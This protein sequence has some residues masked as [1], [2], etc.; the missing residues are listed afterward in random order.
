VAAC[1]KVFCTSNDVVELSRPGLHEVDGR[2][3]A[4]QMRPQWK[5]AASQG[6]RFRAW[7]R[8]KGRASVGQQAVDETPS[9][10]L[11]AP[12]HLLHRLRAVELGADD[13]ACQ[14]E[15]P[16]SQQ[17]GPAGRRGDSMDSDDE[18]FKQLV[19][20]VNYGNLEALE[21]LAQTH[22]SQCASVINRPTGEGQTLL[23]IAVVK[24]RPACVEQLLAMG[25]D[26][27]L[28]CS[29]KKKKQ[30]ALHRA[31]EEGQAEMVCSLLT[32]RPAATDSAFRCNIYREDAAGV[33]CLQ[34]S[35]D[36][37]TAKKQSEHI[38]ELLEAKNEQYELEATE[39]YN[40]CLTFDCQA[41]SNAAKRIFRLEKVINRCPQD[42]YSLLYR[43]CEHGKT[44]VVD[45]LVR[46]GAQCVAHPVTGYTPLYV[47][48]GKGNVA[49]VERL[50]Y[51]CPKAVAIATTKE[52]MLPLHAACLE[53][54]Y[55]VAN[56]LLNFNY[57]EDCLQKFYVYS[58]GGIGTYRAAFDVNAED[59]EGY[60][61]LQLA[62]LWGH[63]DVLRCLLS[64]KVSA[65]FL[66]DQLT[67]PAGD[68]DGPVIDDSQT[69]GGGCD[70]TAAA[71]VTIVDNGRSAVRRVSPLNLRS[72]GAAVL[73]LAVTK[74]QPDVVRC[75]LGH[76]A[77]EVNADVEFDGKQ[78]YPLRVAVESGS[79][80]LADLLM[81]HG[82]VDKNGQ[83][84]HEALDQLDSKSAEA[85]LDSSDQLVTLL[86]QHLASLDNVNR[87]NR[88]QLLGTSGSGGAAGPGGGSGAASA[89]SGGDGGLTDC[90]FER[91][92]PSLPRRPVALRWC[93]IR[94]LTGIRLAWLLA[95]CQ[96]HNPHLSVDASPDVALCAVTKVDLSGCGLAKLPAELLRLRSLRELS[97]ANNA[98]QRL[99]DDSELPPATP[100]HSA[101]LPSLA[102]LNVAGNRLTGLPDWLFTAGRLP[103]LATL[104]CSGNR[105]DR[106]PARVWFAPRLQLLDLA[107]NC[108]SSLPVK[109]TPDAWPAAAAAAVAAAEAA[110]AASM[111]AA[112]SSSTN[113]SA[114]PLTPSS[115]SGIGGSSMF[116]GVGGFEPG[117]VM[118]TSLHLNV[119]TM[120]EYTGWD[121]K[122]LTRCGLQHET[123][124]VQPSPQSADRTSSQQQQQPQGQQ[125]TLNTLILK[126]NR[127]RSCPKGLSCLASSLRRLDL[128]ANQITDVSHIWDFPS[129]LENLDLS[130]NCIDSLEE[131]CR[132]DIVPDLCFLTQR[133]LSEQQQQP[134][135]KGC[136][137]RQ[138][139]VLDQ[140]KVLNLRN[141]P[142]KVLQFSIAPGGVG[143]PAPTAPPPPSTLLFPALNQLD[144]S[145]NQH[146]MELP[147]DVC[148]MEHLTSLSL[149]W[150]AIHQLPPSLSGLHWLEI[151]SYLKSVKTESRP[152]NQL[153]LMVVGNANIGKT[154]LINRLRKLEGSVGKSGT[155]AHR[156][157]IEDPNRDSGKIL[158]TVG[159]DIGDLVM[160]RK[161]HRI[162]EIVFRT[163]D[164]G[165]QKEY[166]ATHQY[167]LSKRAI[168]L[169]VWDLR[170]GD[171]GMESVHQWLVNIHS[172]APRSSVIIVGTHL[173]AL[174]IDDR[175]LREQYLREKLAYVDQ[176]FMRVR[177]PS[178]LGI[179]I[180][181][182]QI[183]VSCVRGTNLQ[184]LADMLFATAKELTL[185][186]SRSSYIVGESI[187]AIYMDLETVLRELADE[188]KNQ[189]KDPVLPAEDY[190]SV[191]QDRMLDK[192]GKSFANASELMQAT[193]FL[194]DVGSILHFKD[195]GLRDIYFLDPQW[196]CDLLAQVVTTPE[197]NK[198]VRGGL[199][200]VEHLHWVFHGNSGACRPAEMRSYIVRLLGKFELALLVENDQLLIPSLL[201]VSPSTQAGGL[202]SRA[203]R[204]PLRDDAA[205]PAHSL[206]RAKL[207]LVSS[208][209]A[210]AASASVAVPHQR[211]NGA[212]FAA[213]SQSS[214]APVYVPFP[215][216]EPGTE[217]TMFYVK[218]DDIDSR[219]GASAQKLPQSQQQQP[220]PIS[221]QPELR[222]GPTKTKFSLKC[223]SADISRQ[224]SRLYIMTYFPSGFWP[225]LLTKLI[226]DR[227]FA[228]T[229]KGLYRLSY[230]QGVE[231]LSD[232]PEALRQRA[233]WLPWQTGV[234]LYACDV[235]LLKSLSYRVLFDGSQHDLATPAE[236]M[237]LL[238]IR[239]PLTDIRLEPSEGLPGTRIGS[240]H[241]RCSRQ[242]ATGLLN[243]VVEHIDSL[244]EDWFPDLGTRFNQTAEG[245][246]LVTRL[247]PCQLCLY[248]QQVSRRGV[249]KTSWDVVSNEHFP[250]VI[251]RVNADAG[252]TRDDVVYCAAVEEFIYN[253]LEKQVILQCPVHKKEFNAPD[254]MFQDLDPDKILSIEQVKILSFIGKG[255]FGTVFSG[256]IR[257]K[258]GEQYAAVKLLVPYPLTAD[259]SEEDQRLYKEEARR[260]EMEAVQCCC[261]SYLQAR[262]ELHILLRLHHPNVLNLY[263]VLA[264][265]PLSLLLELAPQGALDR[266]LASYRQAGYRL[267]VGVLRSL[268]YQI[269]DALSHLHSLCIIYRDLKAENCLVWNLPPPCAVG[270]DVNDAADAGVV[271]GGSAGIGGGS[272]DRG[273][274]G[275]GNE[276][277]AV[278]GGGGQPAAEHHHGGLLRVALADY[279]IS[280]TTVP[281]GYRG[282]A[283]TLAYMAPEILEFHGEETYT[284]KA[285]IYSFGMLLYELITLKPPFIDEA[286]KSVRQNL[287]SY[288]LKGGRPLL[289]DTD[290][291]GVPVP[292]LD[293][294][295]VCWAQSSRL[296]PSAAQ[297]RAACQSAAFVRVSDA[298]AMRAAPLCIGR[299]GLDSSALWLASLEPSGRQARLETYELAKGRVRRCRLVHTFGLGV[300]PQAMCVEPDHAKLW[301]GLS[302]GILAV[303]D[304]DNWERVAEIPV[305]RPGQQPQ[306]SFQQLLAARPAVLVFL[307]S[308]GVRL[309]GSAAYR[310]QTPSAADVE[311]P[312]FEL[313][314]TVAHFLPDTGELWLG[315]RG[316]RLSVHSFAESLAVRQLAVLDDPE[317]ASQPSAAANSSKATTKTTALIDSDERGELVVSYA[318]PG[319]VAQLWS[320]KDRRHLG[321]V[322]LT[323]LLPELGATLAGAGFS[324][325]DCQITALAFVGLELVLGA[326][327]GHVAS[328]NPATSSPGQLCVRLHRP[329]EPY[330]RHL[331]SAGPGRLLSIGCGYA[332][333]IAAAAASVAAGSSAFVSG[334]SA[335]GDSQSDSSS[336]L[337]DSAASYPAHLI[338]LS[339]A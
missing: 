22:A 105:I 280:R 254:L 296:R 44:D 81:R 111:A 177:E 2:I 49:I 52:R 336:D 56:L 67:S 233:Y 275:G 8:T 154:T 287:V 24:G 230:L 194:H 9:S 68:C 188:R 83:L 184:A 77:G 269:A 96:L 247:C 179:P 259:C 198:W 64:F 50:I 94:R 255:N 294:L 307:A 253:Y 113:T 271:G 202:G 85:D 91:L 157:G 301:V 175:Q 78:T 119:D 13:V 193:A 88:D 34:L 73:A 330:V 41:I 93:D 54:H 1:Y 43:A 273:G 220:P 65:S 36:K 174:D 108:L 211:A 153:K 48:C 131:W 84:L 278:G 165:G 98:I 45:F 212:S 332:D 127:L 135:P 217:A 266:H 133:S 173:D 270:T 170:T 236:Q 326:A 158:S 136:Q 128:G 143:Q 297:I 138:H 161:G 31:I 290:V 15:S 134:M 151:L 300:R 16:K 295:A 116:L 208:S 180:V 229:A 118:V 264:P 33:S 282:Y 145:R 283:G 244:L 333:P 299:A 92:Y 317:L 285:D 224:L 329:D 51:Q 178:S 187:P 167:F 152:Y 171:R 169:V 284:E 315:H 123:L 298:C 141:N 95:A 140:L 130:G 66:L 115:P 322:C 215:P 289:Y 222:L 291:A 245:M 107:D 319:S 248:A 181:R 320:A 150:T 129:G 288:I 260:W 302:T 114:S 310:Q 139:R 100:G 292:L 29:G 246:F 185:P 192:F 53:G 156:Q 223:E 110:A 304:C 335:T 186:G 311:P 324:A 206:E 62:T 7:A 226:G 59:V 101:L 225:R 90:Q 132:T 267:P 256:S 257:T 276:G 210:A 190:A 323:E 28:L 306:D 281:D 293:L 221:T 201:P 216:K 39:F 19:D 63:L 112:V 203:S 209:S 121:E 213:S 12:Q 61:A 82:A 214:S 195:V 337:L 204:I 72:K 109:G 117:G 148:R 305:L 18:L 57:P 25:S 218:L 104:V 71:S 102:E 286:T 146:L 252:S 249:P 321:R 46:N 142:V 137:H 313:R 97:L 126:G 231:R 14:L 80:D 42:S 23:Y 325:T 162:E 168:Y 250:T 189:S 155:W 70:A 20:A 75:L 160:R 316:G 227:H 10:G 3:Q 258:E 182:H 243:K 37:R 144:L 147:D 237:S 303:F 86:L 312:A 334:A 238:E 196:L 265:K 106:L 55:D 205:V 274:S 272:G 47:A 87:I 103:L 309:Y 5:N 308:G 318:F 163:W 240:Y 277:A 35:K 11:A 40:L 235:L 241:L 6:T 279:G 239:L 228:N 242:A 79:L 4:D 89:G 69:G 124:E 200:P 251:G 328:Y 263:G 261:K 197:N 207:S 38:C 26:P 74:H 32:D 327:S 17:D 199:M 58:R 176:R 120:A 164:F 331:C 149:A 314:P 125:H 268:V 76:L 219:L 60:S 122:V 30:T 232:F 166:Y 21:L 172:R 338:I 262:S 183:H 339:A 234:E 27:N 191:V 99:P 159:V